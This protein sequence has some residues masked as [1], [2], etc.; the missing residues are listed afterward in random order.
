MQE[1]RKL[2]TQTNKKKSYEEALMWKSFSTAGEAV[3]SSFD[4]VS[5]IHYKPLDT[6]HLFP[7]QGK[8][9]SLIFMVK[10]IQNNCINLPQNFKSLQLKTDAVMD[11]EVYTRRAKG[12]SLLHPPIYGTSPACVLS[13]TS[14]LCHSDL[15]PPF[16]GLIFS[17]P[18]TVSTI[19]KKSNKD[20]EHLQ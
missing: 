15:S 4:H 2:Y 17:N 8:N 13:L 5:P 14:H 7:L 18:A 16:Y 10:K 3:C 12:T 9:W 20:L 11:Q 1:R 6:H 19:I